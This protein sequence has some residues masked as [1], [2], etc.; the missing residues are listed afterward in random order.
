MR[1]GST[2]NVAR[3]DGEF[4]SRTKARKRASDILFEAAARRLLRPQDLRQL[5]VERQEIG[6]T[7]APVP[8]YAQ[9]IVMG[10][11]EKLPQIDRLIA[12]KERKGG[13]DRLPAVDLAVM[14]VA[15]WEMLENPE[16]DPIVA[17]DEA[18]AIVKAISTEQSPALVNAILD[19][20]RAEID[21]QTQ[22]DS[23]LGKEDGGDIDADDSLDEL[24]SE[25]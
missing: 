21:V 17:I 1:D 2:T 7:D 23:A 22:S 15:V 19:A 5:L 11:S 14:R 6:A 10:V 3:R 8:A 25:Y 9:Q 24:L 4:T 16:V 18:V 13:L 20:V 12:E